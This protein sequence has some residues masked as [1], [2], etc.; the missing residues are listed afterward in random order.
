MQ[1][2]PQNI[3]DKQAYYYHLNGLKGFS[4][5]LVMIGHYIGIYRYAQSFEATI[6]VIDI[7]KKSD[8]SFLITAGYWLY[9]FF[10]VS[11]YLVAKSKI[12]DLKAL[13][14]KSINRFL[15]LAFPILFS[16]FII[17]LIYLAFGFH[18]G[19]TKALFQCRWFQQYYTDT[20][21]FMDVLLSPYEVILREITRL[22][23][24]YWVL[25]MMFISSLL[26]YLLKYLYFKLKA[27]EHESL[28]LSVL[29]IITISSSAIS[30]IITACLA[31]ML[32]SF[33]EK[34]G[35]TA[36]PCYAFWFLVVAMSIYFWPNNLKSVIFFAALIV[37]IPRIQFLNTIFSSKLFQFFG[38]IS[39]G[40]YSFH[41][42]IICSLGALSMIRIAGR[43][44][45]KAAYA[46][47]FPFVFILTILL[48]VC[49]YYTLERLAAFLTKKIN[50]LLVQLLSRNAKGSAG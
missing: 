32:V 40:I 49:F 38:S 24:P 33:Y 48:S 5:L 7:L 34:S 18:T 20:Y 6:K 12:T 22:N 10:V 36:K 47:T 11:G 44:G 9:L 14:I 27:A 21:S 1:Y 16:Y 23:R 8:F 41:W 50:G 15:R 17:Y 3:T 19:D 43:I 42:P 31:G 29:M 35:I 4:C 30:P 25:R 45:L 39:W 46:V 13:L 28:A 2:K 26:I 37:F